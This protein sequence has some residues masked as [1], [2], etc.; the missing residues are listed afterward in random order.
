MECVTNAIHHHSL[1]QPNKL[2][3]A[4]VNQKGIISEQMNYRELSLS[5]NQMSTFLINSTPL[6]CG[7]KALLLFTKGI[8][9]IVM[10][11]ACLQS[12][13]IPIPLKHPHNIKKFST[14]LTII[15]ECQPQCILSSDPMD[16][17][18]LCSVPWIKYK[19]ECS[20]HCVQRPEKYPEIAF[21]QYTSG[22]IS[23]P[24]GV[25][26]SH[27][28]LLH[29]L[30]LIGLY[31]TNKSSKH[32]IASW[33]PHYHDMGL[34]GAYLASLYHGYTGYYMAPTTFMTN[35]NAF[36]QLI[37]DTKATQIQCPN[38][39]YEFM[40]SQWDGR[41]VDLSSLNNIV[42]AAEP[43]HSATLDKFYET[44][45]SM[46]LRKEALR[47]TYG[48]AE[49]TLFVTQANTPVWLAKDKKI[50]CGFC[51]DIEIRIVDPQTQIPC[52]DG[53]EGEIWL[54]SPSNALGYYNKPELTEEIFNAKIPGSTKN[55]LKTGDLGFIEQQQ[56]YITGRIKEIIICNG[57]NIYPQDIEYTVEQFPGIQPHGCV[58]VSWEGQHETQIV[59]IAEVTNTHCLPDMEALT[60]FIL[61]HHNI[62]LFD[63]VLCSRYTLPKTTSGKMKRLTCK[64][65]YKEHSITA[66]KQLKDSLCMNHLVKQDP[67][68]NHKTLYEL[69]VT[70]LILTQLHGQ[71]IQKISPEYRDQVLVSRLYSMQWSE[72]QDILNSESI[73][74]RDRLIAN[75]L[76]RFKQDS[77]NTH[78]QIKNDARLNC[79][80]EPSI[81]PA[82]TKNAIHHCLLTGST[83]FIGAYLCFN[84][85]KMTNYQLVLLVNAADEPTGL[86]RV[87][88]NLDQYGLLERCQVMGLEQRVSI[89]CGNLAKDHLGLEPCNWQN[90]AE[91]IDSIYH[92]GAITHYLSRYEVLK[93]SNVDGTNTMIQLA[94]T[95]HLKYIHY[96]STT[97]IFGWTPKRLLVEDTRNTAFKYV[98][99]GY[100][101]SKWVAEQLIW[102]S[103]KLGIPIQIYRPAMVTASSE[104]QYTDKD[105]VARTLVYLLNHQ[106]AI[107]IPNQISFMPVDQ[108]AEDIIAISLQEHPKHKVYH[109]AAEYANLP[110]ICRYFSEHYHYSFNYMSLSEFNNHLQQHATEKDLIYPLVSFFNTHYKKIEKMNKKRYCRN[111][112]LEA[113]KLFQG[114]QTTAQFHET[115][116]FIMR[117]LQNNQLIH[118]ASKT[119]LINKKP[120]GKKID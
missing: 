66:W 96:I 71:L 70:S 110:M 12:G 4:W 104:N 65:L 2:A 18:E 15:N 13:I 75:W 89:L 93:P 47:P 92:N 69:G 30:E 63:L 94:A 7:D 95:H 39:A 103:E 37:S 31:L 22:S 25:M 78:H 20:N 32:I 53:T 58:A 112:Y 48:L 106:V 49:A 45:K 120:A 84:L 35:P 64:Q 77:K 107:D 11:L 85:L 3:L 62:S 73:K 52:D 43:V 102:Q 41:T 40:V 118:P 16:T 80:V 44:F 115:L 67:V 82:C 72:Y 57:I 116:D 54:H 17:S 38:A 86:S 10:F 50:S 68:Q 87:L 101:E 9:F 59:I 5:I 1:T 97:L 88:K 33:L 42:N 55:Y 21:L 56:L 46:G 113:K 14:I 99:F 28:N 79:T 119:P 23:A 81:L 29:N 19:D 109:L 100:A 114:E 60:Q 24:K 90:L 26:V 34:I 83:G 27:E 98:D 8:D 74:E 111:N 91:T 76:K 105:I 61:Q 108:T 51:P 117:Y 36:I 6:R